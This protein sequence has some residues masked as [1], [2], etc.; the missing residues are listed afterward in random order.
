[1]TRIGV[2]AEA[3]I[4]GRCKPQLL[5]AHEGKWV[6]GL[7]AAML[8]D[9]LDG[10][11]SVTADEYVVFAPR[12]EGEGEAAESALA[13]LGRHVPAPWE[14]VAQ[15]SDDF[16]ARVEQALATLLARGEGLAILS[17]SDAP[18]IPIEPLE[19]A[20]AN[21]KPSE[22]VVGPNEDGGC[23]LLAMAALHPRLVRDVPW[24][25]PAAMAT[26]RARCKEL[27][28]T[29]RE[30]PTWYDVDEP[31]DVLKL[32]DE[33]RKHPERAPRTAQFLVTS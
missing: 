21:A 26:L 15:E 7:Y 25:T 9:T 3:P 32:L 20:T 29:L 13:I 31:S 24:T 18:S 14:I 23:Y 2:L 28:L 10:M 4:A 22:I 19:E 1:M 12:R 17:T 6:A 27:G 16:G 8:R 30:L 33:L 11:Q 5:A